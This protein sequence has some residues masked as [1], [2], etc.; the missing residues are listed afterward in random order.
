MRILLVAIALITL[1]GCGASTPKKQFAI[2]DDNFYR[3]SVAATVLTEICFKHDQFPAALR[4]EFTDTMTILLKNTESDSSRIL[5]EVR[6]LGGELADDIKE[7][8]ETGDYSI[9]EGSCDKTKLV[10][11]NLLDGASKVVAHIE[12]EKR[13][14]SNPKGSAALGF[15]IG[16]ALFGQDTSP[17]Y[18]GYRSSS[19]SPVDGDSGDWRTRC[20]SRSD[21]SLVCNSSDKTRTRCTSRADGSVV[22]NKR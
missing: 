8:N 2:T 18:G 3:A 22:C 10:V 19:T 7:S 11:S 21:G 13:E 6:Y 4:Q 1:V 14:S 17:T 15:A 12:E 16:R 5:D 20:S 9:E